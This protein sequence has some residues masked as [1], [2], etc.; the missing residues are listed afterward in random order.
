M[1]ALPGLS[2][3]ATYPVDQGDHRTE[4]EISDSD[5][6]VGDQLRIELRLGSGAMAGQSDSP[7]PCGK[8]FPVSVSVPVS[9]PVLSVSSPVG[10]SAP[11]GL[12]GGGGSGPTGGAGVVPSGFGSPQV[13][14]MGMGAGDVFLQHMLAALAAFRGPVVPPSGAGVGGRDWRSGGSCGSAIPGGFTPVGAPGG[15]VAAVVRGSDVAAACGGLPA[16]SYGGA[17]PFT[18]GNGSSAGFFGGRGFCD[19]GHAAWGGSGPC[20]GG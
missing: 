17:F 19:A 10:G 20:A 12:V 18:N 9:V 14:V 1:A 4:G 16:T 11:P 15:V 3:L 8:S 6:P 5:M 2:S 7:G 13:G